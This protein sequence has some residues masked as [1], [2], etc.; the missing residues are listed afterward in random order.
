MQPRTGP[1][2]RRGDILPLS[3]LHAGD[4]ALVCVVGGKGSVRVRLM[5]LGIVP[6][7]EVQLVRRAPLGDPMQISLR[8]YQLSLRRGEADLIEVES[9]P[10][11]AKVSLPVM[12]G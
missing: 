7:T 9:Q 6:G 11:H 5:E 2:H 3:A 8:G 4:R 1:K 12:R 10:K